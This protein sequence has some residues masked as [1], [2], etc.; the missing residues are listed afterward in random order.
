MSWREYNEFIGAARE[1]YGL[2]IEGAR[3]LYR[4]MSEV[5]G[6]RPEVEDIFEFADIAEALVEPE[7]FEGPE[8]LASDE[9]EWDGY[10]WDVGEPDERFEHEFG[11][12]DIV[13]PGEEVEISATTHGGTGR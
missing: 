8:P 2:D 7:G 5:L 1:A 6:Y 11:E 10:V 3:E 4:D 12:D 9:A 13:Y